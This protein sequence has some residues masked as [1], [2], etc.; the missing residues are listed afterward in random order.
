MIEEQ[1]IEINRQLQLFNSSNITYDVKV[2]A[3]YTVSATP[4]TFSY[5]G[6]HG[7]ANHDPGPDIA[8]RLD[9]W[10][11]TSV[12][13]IPLAGPKAKLK[14]NENRFRLIKE[15]HEKQI[16]K[17]LSNMNIVLDKLTYEE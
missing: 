7:P 1:T 4:G 5:D 6:P 10:H 13:V 17:E 2:T 8:C 9:S 3:Y 12:H 15:T 14:V 16:E 11:I